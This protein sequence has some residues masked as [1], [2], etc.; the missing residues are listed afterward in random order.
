MENG[1]YISVGLNQIMQ[2]LKRKTTDLS[3]QEDD[4]S[5]EVSCVEQRPAK[6]RKTEVE[7]WL[8]DVQM[9][10]QEVGQMM[11]IFSLVMW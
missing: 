1:L 8:R 6:R 7:V 11:N 3:C 4:I 10:E 5:A 2:N 9:L